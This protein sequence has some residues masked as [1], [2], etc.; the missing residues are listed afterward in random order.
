MNKKIVVEI[1]EGLG[2]QMFMYAHAYSLAKKLNYQ[3]EIDNKSGYSRKKNQLRDHQIYFLDKFNISQNITSNDNIYDNSFKRFKKKI[4]IYMYKFLKKKK[5]IIEKKILF[6]GKKIPQPYIINDSDHLSN[7]I[8][9]LGN[10]E[11]Y[12]YFKNLRE[13]LIKIF[14]PLDK[15]IKRQDEL[16]N[17]LIHT[18]SVSIHIRQ[19]RFSDQK[20]LKTN[21]NK[22]HKS[23]EFTNDVITY[24]K[25]AEQFFR[26]K[27]TN[28]V[29][30]IWSNDFAGLDKYFSKE[31]YYFITDNDLINDFNLFS[32]AKHF[33]VSPSTFHWWGAYLNE[34]PD[35]ICIRPKNINPSN[36]TGFWPLNWIAI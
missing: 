17:K 36:N 12:N 9:V 26:K 10:F 18:N 5:F 24:I 33:I 15:F 1:A 28:P 22:L 25:N 32:Y 34:N 20:N 16:I 31:K 13:D 19:N 21:I 6:R 29:F 14:K 8:Y 7:I 27:L 23:N 3:L 30:F 2:N 4:E 11:N 35:K